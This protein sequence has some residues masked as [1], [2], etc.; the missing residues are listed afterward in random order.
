MSLSKSPHPLF[1]MR[2]VRFI[3]L[4]NWLNL[5]NYFFYSTMHRHTACEGSVARIQCATGKGIK[6]LS[7]NYGR[8]STAI[9]HGANYINTNTC[10][11]PTTKL[12][13]AKFC[14]NRNSCEVGANSAVFGDPC[15]SI[16]KYLRV[17][18][19]CV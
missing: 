18:Y 15:K 11:E 14:D 2:K 8:L 10:R 19:A 6:V 3:D 13:V 7:A 12:K 1:F 4:V 16:Y 17:I 5:N 9:C